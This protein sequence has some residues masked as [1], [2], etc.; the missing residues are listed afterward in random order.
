LLIEFAAVLVWFGRG[1]VAWLVAAGCFA[2]AAGCAGVGAFAVVFGAGAVGVGAG[3]SPLFEEPQAVI[4][5][6]AESRAVKL[7][8]R[9]LKFIVFDLYFVGFFR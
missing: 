3:L 7:I 8:E 4:K 5:R 6:T 1:K 9:L 2:G